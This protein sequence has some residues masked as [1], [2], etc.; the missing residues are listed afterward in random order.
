MRNGMFRMG[1]AW[2][3]GE[4]WGRY[5]GGVENWEDMAKG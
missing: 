2:C 1:K 4:E 5:D 3:R